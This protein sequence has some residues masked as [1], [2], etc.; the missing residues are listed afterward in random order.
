[1]RQSYIVQ[2][3]GDKQS[4]NTQTKQSVAVFYK[5]SRHP[6]LFDLNKFWGYFV[7]CLSLSEVNTSVYCSST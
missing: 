1:M 5:C 3:Q 7:D 2:M 6:V 4:R